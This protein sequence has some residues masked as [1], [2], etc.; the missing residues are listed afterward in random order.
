MSLAVIAFL[1]LW[2]AITAI[3]AALYKLASS[4]VA[5]AEKNYEI[6]LQRGLTAL[7]LFVP[8]RNLIRLWLMSVAGL[9]LVMWWVKLHIVVSLL[10]LAVLL[11]GP[12]I[13]YRWLLKR[14]AEQFVEQLPD[15]CLFIANTL[16]TGGTLPTA[17]QFI[18]ANT[19]GAVA[20]EFSLMLRQLRLGESIP[21]VFNGLY[22]R[23]P[24]EELERV[25]QALLLGRESGGQQA[26]LMEKI[27][28]SLRIKA[29]LVQRVRSLSAQGR[30]QGHVMTALPIFLG[31][32]LWFI[33]PQA[34]RALFDSA[35]GWILTG[36]MAFLLGSGHFLIQKM[37]NVEVPL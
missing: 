22:Q 1:L 13:A 31:S 34:M 27:G 16:R 20:Q 3:T 35:L 36:I 30:M 23:M 25:I 24:S 5:D 18:R 26:V 6:R 7:F 19:T 17:L 4:A 15:V 14:R 9:A 12:P 11:A 33:E 10:A 2:A 28:K 21:D 29:Q 37:I 32:V 8:V